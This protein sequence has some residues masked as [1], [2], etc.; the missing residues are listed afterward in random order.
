MKKLFTL[1]A[2]WTCFMGA[3]AIE[4]VDVDLDFSTQETLWAW[5]HGWVDGK[6]S[7]EDSPFDLDDGC[8]HYHSEEATGNNFDIQLQPFPGCKGDVDFASYTITITL[9]GAATGDSPE[10]RIWLAFGGSDTPGWVE[11]PADFEEFTFTDVVNNHTAQYFKDSNTLL[12]QCG[13]FVGDFWIKSIKITHDEKEQA[14]VEWINIIQ[15]GDASAPWGNPD[16][17]VVNNAYDGEGAEE[18]CAYSK[19]FG[20]NDNNPHAAF[21]EDGYFY[22]TTVPVDDNPD[23]ASEEWQNQFWINFPRALKAGEHFQLSFE[24][25]ASEEAKAPGQGHKA[26][27]DYLQGG[28]G[29]GDI[30]FT[31]EWQKFETEFDVPTDGQ[32]SIAFNLGANGGY[33]KA[34]T[35]YFKN[36]SLSYM[37][38]EEGLFVIATDNE[39]STP[40]YDFDNIASFEMVED[41]GDGTGLYQATVGGEADDEWVNEVMIGT[42]RGND[43]GF[44]TSTIKVSGVIKN[45]VDQWLTYAEV[46]RTKT[47]LP[48][49][50]QWQISID[51][52]TKQINFVKLVGDPDLIYLDKEPNPAEI[53]LNGLAKISADWDNQLW[54]AANR[55]L[56]AGEKFLVEFDYVASAD[57][58]T[59][60]QAHVV[61]ADDLPCSYKHWDCG[62]GDVNFT[63]EE[64][65][66]T[67]V[68]T[69]PNDAAGMR[70]ICFNMACVEEPVDYTI[71]NIVWM[72]ED[73]TERLIEPDQDPSTFI[74]R[75]VGAGGYAQY[76][77]EPQPAPADEPED[78]NG[79]G[80]INIGDIDTIIEHIGEDKD[81][82]NA[83]CDVNG[84]GDINVGDIDTVIEAIQ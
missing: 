20:Y 35:Y 79:D 36:L 28:W 37:D 54:I 71:K 53:T 15:N 55:D 66:F 56:A 24:Y 33:Q 21:M 41:Y 26:P 3:N 48:V 82:T 7:A 49:K 69:I 70:S 59:S 44:M 60:T 5:G 22:T 9:K 83:K 14:P 17:Q 51:T 8:L 46:G 34:I 61:G 76:P 31:T 19:E 65:H 30:S 78:V 63:T 80:D 68:I 84:D 2:L 52:S 50:G 81:D 58:K 32:Q 73:L 10:N 64:Q 72:S 13:H 16:A 1:L 74:Y 38:L 67:K 47:A 12:L 43:T 6:Y 29:T 45:D 40:A 75:K 4:V 57:A 23:D 11:V 27:G 42:K 62:V 39:D 25:K 18:I 77:D